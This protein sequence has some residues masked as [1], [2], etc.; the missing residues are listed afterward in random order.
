MIDT[1]NGTCDNSSRNTVLE[2]SSQILFIITEHTIFKQYDNN[3]TNISLPF[4]LTSGITYFN[5]QL[6]YFNLTFLECWILNILI[7]EWNIENRRVFD[8]FE[9]IVFPEYCLWIICSI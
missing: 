3:I 6:Q 2:V 1:P 5:I 9:N 4:S 7:L 8:H